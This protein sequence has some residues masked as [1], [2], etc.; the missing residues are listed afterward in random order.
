[1]VAQVI[2]LRQKEKESHLQ[3]DITQVD[4]VQKYKDLF[5][6]AVGGLLNRYIDEVSRAWLGTQGEGCL[7]DVVIDT[8]ASVLPMLVRDC[9]LSS[10]DVEE[11]EQ[12]VE[13]AI[14][15]EWVPAHVTLERRSGAV[16][17]AIR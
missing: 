12:S 2:A 10:C 1:M 15:R 5:D 3:A 7:D 17:R 11:F 16:L 6:L 8:K 14:Q 4:K 9:E 13:R